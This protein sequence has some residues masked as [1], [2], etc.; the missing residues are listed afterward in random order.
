MF[1]GRTSSCPS[2]CWLTTIS[3]AAISLWWVYGF[4]QNLPH[5]FSTWV[6][7]AEELFEVRGQRS[8]SYN[9]YKCVNDVT[10]VACILTVWRPSRL[11]VSR[12]P[13]R[14]DLPNN[15]PLWRGLQYTCPV[16][17]EMGDRVG[18]NSRCRTS[19]LVCNQPATLGQLSLPF[20]RGR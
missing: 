11:L 18:F 15:L 20:L 12:L 16:S 1:S 6:G 4:K 14:C 2:L 3:R 17:T 9:M 8:R 19:I 13:L 7:I 5:I 10:A